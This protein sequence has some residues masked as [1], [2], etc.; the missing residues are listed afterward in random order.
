MEREDE[1]SS[2][3]ANEAAR[4]SSCQGRLYQ[5]RR[6]KGQGGWEDLEGVVVTEDGYGKQRGWYPCVLAAG[7]SRQAISWRKYFQLVFRR[8]AVAWVIWPSQGRRHGRSFRISRIISPSTE[9]KERAIRRQ[10][11]P[12][13]TV[14]YLQVPVLSMGTPCTSLTFGVSTSRPAIIAPYHP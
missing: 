8:V 3:Y 4:E 2:S 7:V 12:G 10:E 11:R 9:Q 1:T 5:K 6:E 14:Q 13:E